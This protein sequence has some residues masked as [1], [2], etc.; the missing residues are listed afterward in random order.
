MQDAR[1]TK[2]IGKSQILT[3]GVDT[4]WTSY[5]PN[6]EAA[7]SEMD[8]LKRVAKEEV[9]KEEEEGPVDLPYQ[10]PFL[11]YSH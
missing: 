10:H 8:S 1:R 6:S 11:I 7:W 4:A 9:G 5:L 3:I 2:E